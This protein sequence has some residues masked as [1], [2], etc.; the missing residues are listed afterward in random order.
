MAV[1][2]SQ[3]GYPRYARALSEADC[4]RAFG[5]TRRLGIEVTGAWCRR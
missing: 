3:V 2:G 4:E 5:V 1:P